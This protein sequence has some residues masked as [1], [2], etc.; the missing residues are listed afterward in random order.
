MKYS[1]QVAQWSARQTSQQIFRQ[2]FRQHRM[3]WWVGSVLLL[4]GALWLGVAAWQKAAAQ[5]A[6]FNI[7]TVVGSSTTTGLVANFKNAYGVAAASAT[8]FYVADTG[9]H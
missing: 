2:R 3:Y 7:N 1:R 6:L 9:N 8:V 5:Q 4:T